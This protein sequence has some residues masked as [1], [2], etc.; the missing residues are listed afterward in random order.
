MNSSGINFD[1][2]EKL[3]AWKSQE[4]IAFLGEELEIWLSAEGESDFK[5]QAD[6]LVRALELLPRRED[7]AKRLLY[8]FYQEA[9]EDF[10]DLVG[11]ELLPTL[12][13]SD[14]IDQVFGFSVL[15][16]P[17]QFPGRGVT[18]KVVGGCS[19]NENDGIQIFFRDGVIEHVD[20]DAAFYR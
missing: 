8:E 16:I 10:S 13:S 5:Q 19:W 20:S 3:N 7:E 17:E 9:C 12:K 11:T 15:E 14:N 18:F 4:K 1:F 2:D 6:V